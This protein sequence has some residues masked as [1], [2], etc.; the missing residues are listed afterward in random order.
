MGTDIADVSKRVCQIAAMSS[1]LGCDPP[2]ENGALITGMELKDEFYEA[3]TVQTIEANGHLLSKLLSSYETPPAKS[4]LTAVMKQYRALRSLKPNPLWCTEEAN[5]MRLCWRY[6]LLNAS[7]SEGSHSQVMRD[8]KAIVNYWG[9]RCQKKPAAA[10]TSDMPTEPY[11]PG[12]LDG[13]STDNKDDD[14]SDASGP[15][16][17]LSDDAPVIDHALSDDPPEVVQSS[18]SA[19]GRALARRISCVS[20]CSSASGAPAR[21][22]NVLPSSSEHDDDCAYDPI[23]HRERMRRKRKQKQFKTKTKNKILKNNSGCS[24]T[25]DG[26]GGSKT[27][28]RAQTGV[29]A[30]RPSDQHNGEGRVESSA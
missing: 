25:F 28:R 10:G 3:V 9:E 15:G 1:A 29:L 27:S 14:A 12:E 2:A 5:K 19:G 20:V 21:P 17:A 26:S 13:E 24:K 4:T 30:G 23:K 7:R 11:K 8:L 22:L 6:V 16:H 18:S